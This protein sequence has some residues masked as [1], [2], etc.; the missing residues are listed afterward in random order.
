MPGLQHLGWTTSRAFLPWLHLLLSPALSDIHIDLNGGRTTPVNA[1]VIKALPTTHLKHIAFST[2]HTNTEV[3]TALLDLFL[4]ATQ[5]ASI[6]VQQE[7]K[8]DE[9]SP[10]G[11]EVEGEREPIELGGLTSIIIRFKDESIFLPNLF[12]RTTLPKIQQIYL[13]H[14]GKT[15]WLGADDLF[16]SVLQSA[17]PSVL[18]ALRYASHYHGMDITSARIQPLR[19]F[20]ALRT[21]RVT[22]S[23]SMNRCKF[24]LADDDIS[25][26]ASAM[27]NLVEL[28]LGGT[29]C[30]ST[31]V[32]VSMNSLVTLATN[33]TKLTDLQIHFDTADFINRAFDVTGEHIVPLQ[34]TPSSCQ[35]TELNVGRIPVSRGMDGCWAVGM[36]L[37][38]IFPKLKNIK[39]YQQ[40]FG[41]YDWGEVMRVIKVQRNIGN[42]MSSTSVECPFVHVSN[43]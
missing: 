41:A 27:P 15:E 36:A 31:L 4:K 43:S 17:S 37:V 39:Y 34:S 1:A 14:L 33:C 35:L 12:N 24:L 3:D 18:R 30:A 11:G 20:I 8:S 5:L 10:P 42:L 21:I 26:I 22:S 9:T 16:D 32:I 40:L 29:P 38:Q 13:N 28:H 23:C 7:A 6:Y 25:A 19:N 2:L